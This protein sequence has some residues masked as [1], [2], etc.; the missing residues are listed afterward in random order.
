MCTR[1]DRHSISTSARALRDAALSTRCLPCGVL[2][3][4]LFSAPLR[5]LERRRPKSRAPQ[6]WGTSMYRCTSKTANAS[7]R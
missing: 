3:L 1:P 2:L 4:A 6:R 5:L 7:P